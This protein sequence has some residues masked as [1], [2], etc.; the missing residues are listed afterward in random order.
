MSEIVMEIGGGDY[1][2]LSVAVS[3]L[4]ACGLCVFVCHGSD[5]MIRLRVMRGEVL[6]AETL[7][8]GLSA[9]VACEFLGAVRTAVLGLERVE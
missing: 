4:E 8:G 7:G 5:G 1:E 6:V 3:Q 2:A 9:G